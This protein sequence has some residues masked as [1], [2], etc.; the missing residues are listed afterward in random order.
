ML[1]IFTLPEKSND[2]GRDRTRELGFDANHYTT[3]AVILTV[4]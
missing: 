4:S 2:F 3:E 1:R